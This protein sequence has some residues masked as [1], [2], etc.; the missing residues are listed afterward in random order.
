VLHAGVP[1]ATYLPYP[2]QILQSTNK[3]VIAYEFAGATRT[4]HMDT[5]GDSPSPT[6]MGWSRGDGTATR[7]S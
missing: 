2:F 1:R 5:V 3:I 4:V 7:S 6:W